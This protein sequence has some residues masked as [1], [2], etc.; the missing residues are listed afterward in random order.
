VW[1]KGFHTVEKPQ[2]AIHRPGQ[3]LGFVETV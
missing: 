1:K 2:A 3:I